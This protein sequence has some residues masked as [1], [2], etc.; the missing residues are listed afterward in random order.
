MK[1]PL[2]I[3]AVIASRA[4]L[5]G[6]ATGTGV[7]LTTSTARRPLRNKCRDS[8]GNQAGRSSP[9]AVSL[10]SSC[11]PTTSTTA[12]AWLREH[13]TR[14]SKAASCRDLKL[15]WDNKGT[16]VARSWGTSAL[17]ELLIPVATAWT[18]C[19]AESISGGVPRPAIRIVCSRGKRSF[20]LA[21]A[22]AASLLP[23]ESRAS[24]SQARLRM[25][26]ESFCNT[27]IASCG[28]PPVKVSSGPTAPALRAVLWQKR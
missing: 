6:A 5:S 14:M 2:P 11:H 28:T 10:A 7:L 19:N 12:G 8:A 24:S 18:N 15:P 27:G 16:T 21:I 13:E 4:S 1:L 23:K 26:S 17:Q 3:P 22:S 20:S 25:A 9:S